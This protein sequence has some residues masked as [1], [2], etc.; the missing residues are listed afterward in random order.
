MWEF[1]A[2]FDYAN[3]TVG[4]CWALGLPDDKE[5]FAVRVGPLIFVAAYGL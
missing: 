4:V 2:F 5:A 1:D 3:W